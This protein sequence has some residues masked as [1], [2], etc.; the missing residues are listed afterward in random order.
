MRSPARYADTAAH[1]F[2]STR[3]SRRRPALRQNLVH[4]ELGAFALLCA[5]LVMAR[6]HLADQPQREELHPDDDEE[7]AEGQERASA[8]RV[9]ERLVHGQIDQ[10]S[11]SD[12]HQREAEATEQMQGAVAAAADE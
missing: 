9:S 10:D 1:T 6:D 5:L 11:D 12:H 7:D 8:D 3:P 4:V 2:R